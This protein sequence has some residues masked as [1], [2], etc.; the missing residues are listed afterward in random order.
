TIDNLTSRYI[1]K[2]LSDKKDELK[3][4]YRG[5]VGI[6]TTQVPNISVIGNDFLMA[7]PD[8]AF[9][10][11]LSN[12]GTVSL[13]SS[14]RIDVSQMAK[15]LFDGGGH[16]NAAG[17]RLKEYKEQFDYTEMKRMIQSVLGPVDA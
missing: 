2:L 11:D 4:Y 14:N 10:I 5:K 15:Q 9:I 8:I 6:L 12:R 7:N 13:R 1:V 17:G 3:V 16:P